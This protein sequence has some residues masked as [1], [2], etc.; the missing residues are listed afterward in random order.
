MAGPVLLPER[1][2]GL[3]DTP[4]VYQE[5]LPLSECPVRVMELLFP[6]M[7]PTSLPERLPWKDKVNV[8]WL[9]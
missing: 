4:I 3:F 6:E 9:L 2:K 5:V 1:T 7:D 8:K